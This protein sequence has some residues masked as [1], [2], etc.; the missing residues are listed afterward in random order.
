MVGNTQ[1]AAPR[2]AE[3][4]VT[5]AGV[6]TAIV[7]RDADLEIGVRGPT[8][9][10]VDAAAK[11][12]ITICAGWATPRPVVSGLHAF[13]S[14]GLWQLYRDDDRL[15][16]RLTSPTFG[17]L[18]YKTATFAPDFSTGFVDLHRPYFPA[19]TPLYPLEYPLDELL[20]TN[21]LSLGR[22][23]ELHA[24]AVVDRD[25]RGYLFAGHSGAGKTTMARQWCDEP[26]VSVLSDDR[27]VLRKIGAEIWMYGT[28]WHGDE[29]LASPARARLTR[30]FFLRHGSRNEVS[31]VRGANLVAQL[32]SRS[33]P[34][35]H[36]VSGLETTIALLAEVGHIAPFCDFGVVPS[37][38][39]RAFVRGI[40]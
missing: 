38:D 23:V 17:P 18:P 1:V 27:V 2:A 40:N 11:P 33:F 26:G 9:H 30:G 29:P 22:G 31:D 39:V 16:F 15:V 34:P 10:F 7:S 6:T 25:G 8:A 20:L 35:F 28:P 21:W 24:C 4:R 13:D 12:D 5:I 3:L 19:S 37:S 36:S 14:G 32:L